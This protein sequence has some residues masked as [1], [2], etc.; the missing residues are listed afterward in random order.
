MALV[1]DLKLTNVK[2]AV[3]FSKPELLIS[4][5]PDLLRNHIYLCR[6]GIP[7]FWVRKWVERRYICFLKLFKGIEKLIS[8]RNVARQ[9]NFYQK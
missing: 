7:L 5:K 2:L 9:S 6:M 8:L 4:L 1:R 3:E